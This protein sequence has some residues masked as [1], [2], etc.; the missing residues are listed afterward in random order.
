MKKLLN[1]F[2]KHSRI[3]VIVI[4]SVLLL[5]VLGVW[6]YFYFWSGF[7]FGTILENVSVAGVDVGNMT[8]TEAVAAVEEAVRDTYCKT[9]ME[10]TVRDEHLQ[11]PPS[12]ITSSLNVKGAVKKA[13]AYGRTGFPGRRNQEQLQ[14]AT[15]GHEVDLGDYLPIDMKTLRSE[16]QT[17]AA[18]FDR[19]LTQTTYEVTGTAPDLNAENLAEV[20]SDTP[21]QTLVI[22][23]GIPSYDFDVDAVCEQVLKAYSR[24]EFHVEYKCPV[25]DPDPLE[26]DSI[27][28]QFCQAPV[29]AVMDMKTFEVTPHVQG[30]DFD[31]EAAKQQF[32]DAKPGDVLELPFRLTTPEVTYDDLNSMLYR[33]VLSS[34]TAYSG[35]NPDRDVNLKLSCKAINNTVIYP[36]EIFSYNPTLGKRTPEK[37]YRPAAGYVG[38]ETV[39]EYGGGICQASSCL[40][41]TAMLADLEI[42]ERTN[43]GFISSYMPYGMDATV[44]WGG[45]EFRF[46]NNTDYPIRIEAHA[47]GGAVT[48]KLIGTDTKDYYVKMEYNVLGVYDYKVV[49]KEMSPDNPQ[50]YRDGE[51]IT[52]PYTG[53]KVETFRCKYDKETDELI[54]RDHEAT[55]TYSSR[56]KVICKIAE[57]EPTTPPPASPEPT[58]PLPPEPT[59]PETLPPEPTEPETEPTAPPDTTAP[60]ETTAS[61]E[62]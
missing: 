59:E 36:G 17:L 13:Y 11:L 23:K 28:E 49:E 26:L 16:L 45:P 54:S 10:I 57:P 5:A 37:G 39:M 24:N 12:I 22:T 8:V 18:R 14:A 30:Y 31:L 38:S 40:Y 4:C 61:E 43:H 6:S 47:S 58:D 19:P 55:S 48:V 21:W 62:A 25:T 52:T 41:Y 33:D 15:E 20:P 1:S 3:C 9:P 46:R 50:G 42:V 51:V 53:Y 29:D 44:S 7:P 35:S 2:S 60:E 34:F 56:D 32:S 27:Y